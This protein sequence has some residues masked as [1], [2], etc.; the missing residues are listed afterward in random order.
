MKLAPRLSTG[1]PKGKTISDL[2]ISRSM[3]TTFVRKK[4][5]APALSVSRG[6]VARR[7]MAVGSLPSPHLGQKRRLRRG[8][9][10]PLWGCSGGLRGLI[11]LLEGG[12]C[13]GADDAL[14]GM[15]LGQCSEVDVLFVGDPSGQ[16]G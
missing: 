8:A 12:L 6:A 9:P 13:V 2:R 7:I 10:P 5:G 3:L 14:A 11:A 15:S 1:P 4:C 16:R